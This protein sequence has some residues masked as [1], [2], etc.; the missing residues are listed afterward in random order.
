[1]P[2]HLAYLLTF[3]HIHASGRFSESA[4][5]FKVAVLRY[6]RRCSVLTVTEVD[7]NTRAKM[8][9]EPHWEAIWGD[10]G[11]RDDCGVAWDTRVWEKVWAGTVTVAP[12][13]YRNER[14]V[15]AGATAA[16]YAV[17][18]H[19]ITG[20]IYVFGSLH[21][22]H[23]MQTELREGKIHSDVA[24]AYVAIVRGFR[25]E[26]RK[27]ANQYAADGQVL[28]GDYNVN[29]RQLWA[30]AYV[31]AYAKIGGFRLNWHAPLPKRGTHGP[32]IIDLTFYKGLE[33]TDGPTPLPLDPHDDHGA[34]EQE[35]SAAA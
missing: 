18:R 17:L 25:R 32:E 31:A 24:L 30:R 5:A 11:P 7:A 21:T 13:R 4:E 27:L 26:A 16:A 20:K 14:H 19:R 2:I 6:M 23:G 35:F 12:N 29:I 3:V 33:L 15:L 8:L 10:K 9:R 1:M 28:S 22:P 34:Y